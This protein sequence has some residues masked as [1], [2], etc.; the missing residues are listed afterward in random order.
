MRYALDSSL[1]YCD[2]FAIDEVIKVKSSDTILIGVS[3]GKCVG[4]EVLCS[5]TVSTVMEVSLMGFSAFCFYLKVVTDHPA[6]RATV[7]YFV[8]DII[9]DLTLSMF[10]TLK[11]ILS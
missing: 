1:N 6:T 10:H 2:I 4:E 8:R 11:R 9:H 3:R 7:G 5:G